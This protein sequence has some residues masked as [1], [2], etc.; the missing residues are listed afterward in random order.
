MGKL[1][2][3]LIVILTVG[4]VWT[5]TSG[6]WWFTPNISEHGDAIDR[7]FNFTAIVVAIAFVSSQLALAWAIVKFGRKGNERAV[8]SHGNNKVE[9]LWT[10][11]TAGVFIIVAIFGQMVWYRLH[12][13]PVAA[14]AV[15]IEVVAQQFQWNFHYPGAD[16]TMGKTD[17]RYIN[18]GSLNFIGL[19][20][21]DAA[22]KDDIQMSTLIVP[23]DRPVSILMRSKD[24]IHSFWVPALRIKQ[25]AV[26][27]MNVRIHFTAKQV[28]KYEMTCVELCGSLHYNMK[29]FMLVLPQEEYNE[30]TAMEEGNF[31]DRTNELM[32]RYKVNSSELDPQAA[33]AN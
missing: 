29:T 1:L 32:K 27:G 11:I 3:L 20:P 8:Y 7:Q 2:A 23:L 19:D 22:G 4:S 14:N 28:G 10:I 26:P 33:A 21:D 31:K 30:L 9:W 6:N 17:A 12:I 18:D 13:T 5:F 24:V 25:D 16:Q 15:P